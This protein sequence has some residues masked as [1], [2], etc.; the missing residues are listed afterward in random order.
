MFTKKVSSTF[1]IRSL[2]FYISVVFVQSS[3][4]YML[5]SIWNLLREG[6]QL[7]CPF[8]YIHVF[9]KNTWRKWKTV[10]WRGWLFV[11]HPMHDSKP[12]ASSTS[13]DAM[14]NWVWVGMR[15]FNSHKIVSRI[16]PSCFDSVWHAE[17]FLFIGWFIFHKIMV[18]I[19]FVQ[20]YLWTVSFK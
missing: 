7:L 16:R 19:E 6:I 14:L 10:N 18:N 5:N 9:F 11:L 17:P 1:F 2:N 8:I 20:K 13:S 12:V 4:N 3:I 15:I